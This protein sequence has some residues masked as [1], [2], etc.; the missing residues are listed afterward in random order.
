MA[1]SLQEAQWGLLSGRKIPGGEEGV[2]V[3][4]SA[5]GAVGRGCV[6]QWEGAVY[7]SG[8]AVYTAG[9]EPEGRQRQ[10]G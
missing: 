3:R 5:V 1:H 2:E 8:K 9:I 7:R 10:A 6:P 4:G